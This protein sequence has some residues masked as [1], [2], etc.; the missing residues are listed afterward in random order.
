MCTSDKKMFTAVADLLSC[1]FEVSIYS[2]APYQETASK[3]SNIARSY[4]LF[5]F[6]LLSQ[7]MSEHTGYEPLFEMK[8][9]VA[10]L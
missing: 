5:L 8:L 4:S 2:A 1:P 6:T 3:M 7:K 10:G 9:C